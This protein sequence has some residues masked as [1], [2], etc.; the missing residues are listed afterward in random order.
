VPSRAAISGSAWA[1][2]AHT[3]EKTVIT[4]KI[5]HAS[6]R[7][8]WRAHFPLMCF[9]SSMKKHTRAPRAGS[10]RYG[11]AGVSARS[12]SASW[13]RHA[14]IVQRQARMVPATTSRAYCSAIA[15]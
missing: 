12:R 4:T 13:R 8:G 2:V 3:Q 11:N 1:S 7:I 14:S 9:R 6:R 10:Y 5:C 15:A